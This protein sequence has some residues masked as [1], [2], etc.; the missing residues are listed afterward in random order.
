MNWIAHHGVTP[1]Q[2]RDRLLLLYQHLDELGLSEELEE[3]Y[4]YGDH[5]SFVY[6]AE[7]TPPGA[8]EESLRRLSGFHKC[9]APLRSVKAKPYGCSAALRSLDTAQLARFLACKP[10]CCSK[11][12][13]FLSS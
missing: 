13:R 1:G 2:H 10:D 7:V 3:I 6:E 12:G 5:V 4:Y 9:T 8:E 11:N